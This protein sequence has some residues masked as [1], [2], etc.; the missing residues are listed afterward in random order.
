M[1]NNLPKSAYVCIALLLPMATAGFQWILWK[2]I[3]PYVWFLFFPTVFFSSRIGG[4][5]AGIIS[6]VISA[7]LV[8]YIF[9]PPHFTFAGKNPHNLFSVAIF[10]LM[11]ILFSY[12]HE[13]LNKARTA[14]QKAL[15]ENTALREQ[16]HV[17]LIDQLK[18]ER[19]QARSELQANQAKL[20]AALASMTDAV[21]VSDTAGNFI[22]F[23]EAF[24]TFHKF[25]SKDGCADNLAAYHEVFEMNHP[26][27]T[28]ADLEQW[29]VPRALRGETGVNSEYT[30]RRRDTGETWVGC[31]N[32]SPIRDDDGSI[33]GAVV[34]ARD[35]TE[36][37]RAE[38]TLQL[39]EKKFALAFARNPA[40]IALTRLDDGLFY[41][42]NETWIELCGFSREEAIG[43]SARSMNIWPSSDASKRFVEELRKNGQVQWS[44]QRFFNKSGGMFVAQLSAQVLTVQGEEVVLSTMVDIT[45]RMKAEELLR[46]ERLMLRTLIDTIPDLVWLKDTD[47]VYVACNPEFEQ[48]FGATE[49]EIIGKTDHDFVEAELADSFRENDRRAMAAGRPTTNE[50][51]VT[52][53]G[54]GRR[55]LLSTIKTP[56]CT[57]DGRVTGVLGIA[58]D[59]TALKQTEE[60]LTRKNDYMEQFLYTTS[61]DMRT[62]LVT[63]KTFLGFLE[64]DI[65]AGNWERYSQNLKFIHQAT[66]KMKQLLDRLQDLS[67]IGLVKAD[68]AEVALS[69]IIFEAS[70]VLAGTIDAK[71][72]EI[73]LPETDV[74]L[75]GSRES[76]CV[77][78]QN[79]IENAL[80]Y[81]K[82][83]HAPAVRLGVRQDGSETIFFVQDNGIGI[84][85]RYLN[86]VFMMFEKLEPQSPGAGLGLTITKFVI[87]NEGGRIWAESNGCGTGSRFCFTLPRAVIT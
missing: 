36:R 29:A 23:N 10:L 60:E 86:R 72:A 63:V 12:T 15:E 51:W 4:K 77:V 38:E 55:A 47:G 26:D 69:E 40:A 46:S 83:G 43:R 7:A 61:H 18:C 42:V 54:D 27:G 64:I 31:F 14:E 73:H 87:E 28:C 80:I 22:D 65:A 41:E 33:T 20:E 9:I 11:G 19:Q 67:R 57:S 58:R 48:F 52:Y 32:F 35:I 53:A 13:R 5:S 24:A 85:P 21:F 59:V 82:D 75:Y 84:D 30:L 66:D 62:P 1:A 79:L 70:E 34:T 37:K 56:M 25:H 6:T 16:L 74:R 17:A 78:W 68:P 44:E 2:Y 81:G 49:A 76:F 50:E 3:D 45:E 71:R 8:E 39:S